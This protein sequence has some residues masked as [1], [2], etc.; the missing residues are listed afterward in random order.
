LHRDLTCGETVFL[1]PRTRGDAAR[2]HNAGPA[3]LGE[4]SI[5]PV[6]NAA[7]LIEMLGLIG[8]LLPPWIL[9]S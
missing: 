5:V 4:G 8:T 1:K 3:A 6:F 2:R 9:R 7:W